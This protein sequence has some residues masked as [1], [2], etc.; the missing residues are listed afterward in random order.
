MF[1]NIWKMFLV[2]SRIENRKT[3]EGS[4]RACKGKIKAKDDH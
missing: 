2:N 1:G 4:S 3:L